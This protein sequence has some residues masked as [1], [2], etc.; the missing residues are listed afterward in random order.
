MGSATFRD[1]EPPRGSGSR[2]NSLR[3]R[4]IRFPIELD[5]PDLGSN[6]P[7][8]CV[9]DRRNTR[10]SGPAVPGTPTRTRSSIPCPTKY[11]PGSTLA[12]TRRG[13][14]TRLATIVQRTAT[15]QKMCIASHSRSIST[16]NSKIDV[17]PSISGPRNPHESN[18][19]TVRAFMKYFRPWCEQRECRMLPSLVF[20]FNGNALAASKPNAKLTGLAAQQLVEHG[21]R[22]IQ[23]ATPAMDDPRRLLPASRPGACPEQG[24]AH[25]VD[26]LQC[27]WGPGHAEGRPRSPVN[28]GKVGSLRIFTA[29]PTWKIG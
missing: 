29:H 13:S 2:S 15:E 1:A 18:G 23:L 21:D 5:R 3:P 12:S 22:A 14:D 6:H 19:R 7:R 11:G 17:V 9:R 27:W 26:G 10:S 4:G 16:M 24:T 8:R 25:R 28:E 20:L